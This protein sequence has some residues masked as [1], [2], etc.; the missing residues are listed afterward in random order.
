MEGDLN[1]R[2]P[3]K[4]ISNGAVG[5]TYTPQKRPTIWLAKNQFLLI[6]YI[7]KV[8]FKTMKTF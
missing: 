1:A 8:D 3:T 7:S 5:S 4:Y 2:N 6:Y